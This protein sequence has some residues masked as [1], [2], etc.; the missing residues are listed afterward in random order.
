MK[1][2]DT[3]TAA[4]VVADFKRSRHIETDETA[5]DALL[6]DLL[7]AAQA[8]VETGTN[9]PL[10]ARSVEITFRAVG[11]LRW[12]FPCAPVNAVTKIEWQDGSTWVELPLADVALEQGD[13]EPQLVFASGFWSSVSDG[14]AVRV[15]AEVGADEVPRPLREAIILI[16]GDWYEAGINPDKDKREMVSFG[17][18]ILMRQGRYSRPA[19]WAAA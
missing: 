14:A 12:W 5:D 17:S 4:V 10:T 2:L 16:A 3:I 6:E 9:R 11:G 18:R 1:A 7:A 19:E 8:V 15:T 13:D